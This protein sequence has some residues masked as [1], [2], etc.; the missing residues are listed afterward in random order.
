MIRR[1]PRI[2]FWD[3]LPTP[4]G[5]EQY[6]LLADREHLD[7]RV[8]FT[9]R[10]EP[11]RSWDVDETAWRFPG[12]YVEDPS[13]T[14]HNV[15]RFVR[16]CRGIQPDI[17]VSPYGDARFVAGHMILKALRVRTILFVQRTFD[18]W[19]QR[20]WWK[21]VAKMVLCRSAD[22]AQVPGSEGRDAARRYGFPHD[23]IFCARL[24][25]NVEHF[26]RGLAGVER[27]RHR[28]ALGVQ[29]CVFLYVGRL[30]KP[31]GLMTLIEAYREARRANG[32]ISLL[33]VGDGPDGPEIRNAAAGIDGVTFRPFVQAPELPAVYAA[34]DVFVFPTLGDPHGQVIEEAHAAGLPIITTSTVG[35]VNTRV[36]D[37]IDGFV[38]PP[39]DASSLARRMIDLATDT[40]L[41]AVLGERGSA[42]AA[43]WGHEV[44][45]SQT[46]EMVRTCLALPRR[47]TAAGRATSAG[48][49]V[50]IQIAGLVARSFQ[51]AFV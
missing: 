36:D 16:R 3:T 9:T 29:G 51:R 30:W 44:F 2:V 32:A 35:E 11:G 49:M 31:K 26:G 42:R 39:D 5:V 33:I 38:V 6:N 48:G 23:R 34:S 47:R 46:E 4:Y 41:R 50:M 15:D 13:L 21:E 7:L 10:T 1:R 19:I 27:M 37:G 45:A 20:A 43:A 25:T 22:A 40:R 18:A 24:T 14:L 17:V 28:A 12:E 8:W